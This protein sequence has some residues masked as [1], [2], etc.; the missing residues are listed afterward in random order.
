VSLPAC[1]CLLVKRYTTLSLNKYHIRY[2]IMHITLFYC[3]QVSL[4]FYLFTASED[5]WPCNR[6]TILG[7]KREPKP[8]PCCRVLSS[9]FCSVDDDMHDVVHKCS[10]RSLLPACFSVKFSVSLIL[11]CSPSLRATRNN[12]TKALLI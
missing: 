5:S 3:V 10:L 11:P 9:F 12:G 8:S 2:A 6:R 4:A 1:A 7:K